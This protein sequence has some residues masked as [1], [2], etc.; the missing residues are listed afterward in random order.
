[1]I[2]SMPR[3]TIVE[4][5]LNTLEAERYVRVPLLNTIV[6]ELCTREGLEKAAELARSI[7]D[8]LQSGE[9]VEAEFVARIEALRQL[10]QRPFG[11]DSQ[12]SREAL[13]RGPRPGAATPLPTSTASAA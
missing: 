1:M 4:T 2:Q 7:L 10:V 11:P 8:R 13:A 5:L 12:A 6:D 9:L 3:E